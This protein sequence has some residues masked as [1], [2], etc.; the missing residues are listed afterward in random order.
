[1][2]PPVAYNDRALIIGKTTSGKSEI[3]RFLFS[4]MTGAR[5]VLV[6]VKGLADVGVEPIYAPEFDPRAPI[7]NIVPPTTD[8]G[9]IED[10]YAYVLAIGGPTVVWLD[11]A[12]GPTKGGRAPDSLLIVQTQGA[13][14]QI[15]HIVC[16]QRPQDIAVPLR[17]E[18][19]HF[20]IVVPPISYPDLEVLA[21]EIAE[22]DGAPCGPRELRQL[23][24]DV[25]QEHGEH[26]FVWWHRGTGELVVCEPLPP[27]VVGAPLRPARAAS[28]PSSPRDLDRES[29][30][31]DD[32]HDPRE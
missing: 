18:A 13:Q 24:V 1:M 29:S 31:G 22:L 27:E 6:N 15:G 5:R 30:A 2:P 19:E 11:E 17:T 9:F 32:A 10:V 4:L 14:R 25:R 20:F 12:F 3:A 28:L 23:L 16:S 8:Q 7:V 26:S 21:R